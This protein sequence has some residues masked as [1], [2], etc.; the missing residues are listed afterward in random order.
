MMTYTLW[1]VANNGQNSQ[2]KK[3][4]TRRA[5]S[6][7]IV[8]IIFLYLLIGGA[9]AFAYKYLSQKWKTHYCEE[10]ATGVAI[11][12]GVF[13]PIVAPFAFAI[14]TAKEF[15]KEKR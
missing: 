7:L 8:L 2:S 4:C 15:A 3:R 1:G 10:D 12:S 9:L 11:V 6:D 5:V 13:W 14:M